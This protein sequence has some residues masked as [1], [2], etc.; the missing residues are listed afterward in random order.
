MSCKTLFC[1]GQLY[2]LF[3]L[4]YYDCD[5]TKTMEM[6]NISSQQIG[7]ACNVILKTMQLIL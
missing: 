5:F 2:N 6:L 7:E 4:C 1:D 3:S